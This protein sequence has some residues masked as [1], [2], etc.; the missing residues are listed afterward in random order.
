MHPV[1]RFRTC[2]HYMLYKFSIYFLFI[3]CALVFFFFKADSHHDWYISYPQVISSNFRL[4]YGYTGFLVYPFLYFS[5]FGMPLLLEICLLLLRWG[6]P[7]EQLFYISRCML[8]FWFISELDFVSTYRPQ[9]QI[10]PYL[11]MKNSL[12]AKRVL[13]VQVDGVIMGGFML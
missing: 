7:S 10:Q 4:W 12:L 9:L 11:R 1:N 5:F 3:N 2:W 6:G 13:F 8:I